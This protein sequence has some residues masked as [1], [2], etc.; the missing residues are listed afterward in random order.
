MLIG[1]MLTA[2]APAEE[3]ATAV[4]PTA[5][6]AEPAEPTEEP[7]EPTEE[8][9]PP[10]EPAADGGTVI[11]GLQGDPERMVSNIWPMASA[12]T[13]HDLLYSALVKANAEMIFEPDVAESWEYSDDGRTITFKLRDD[14]VFHDGEPLTAQDVAFTYNMMAKPDYNGGQDAFVEWIEGVED[15]REGTTEE[16]AGI[17]VIDD[18]TISFT[19]KEPYAPAI[20]YL[21]MGILPEHI[22]KD[23]PIPELDVHEFNYSPVAS[24]PFKLTTYEPDRQVVLEANDDYFK[25]RPKIDKVIFRIASYEALLNAW[26]KQEIDAVP[27]AIADLESVEET[28]FGSTYEY[29]SERPTYLGI[30]NKSAKFSDPR[31]RQAVSLGLDRQE[32]V[33]VILDGRGRP[34]SQTHPPHMWAYNNDIPVT[35]QD[36]EAAGALLDEAGWTLNADTGIREKDGEPFAI[37]LWYVTDREAYQPDNAAMIQSQLQ[38]LGLEVSLRA[39]DSPSLW[40]TVLPRD[41]EA[42]PDGYDFMIASISITSGDPDWYQTY[43]GS[44]ALPPNGINYFLYED[45]QMDQMLKE[46]AQLM[47]FEDRKAYWYDELWPY[48][49]EEM[50]IIPELAPLTYFAVNNRFQGFQP[51]SNSWGNNELNWTVEK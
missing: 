21:D 7:A 46:Q 34:I 2:C 10:E 26:L 44:W 15:S 51:G 20:T 11:L 12:I 42:D 19:G 17:K 40:P 28:D 31:V 36:L 41:S 24:G 4:P 29:P 38:E 23:V 9:P 50:P 37:E 33:D 43:L 49:L 1:L 8:P 18:Y 16:I 48:M 25:G 5:A 39:W 3:P 30:N 22:L 14:V 47:E 32:I 6:P 13:I 45:E 35:E 27:V